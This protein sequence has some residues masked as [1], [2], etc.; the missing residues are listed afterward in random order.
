MSLKC[1]FSIC[2]TYFDEMLF[3]GCCS[4]TAQPGVSAAA[5]VGS[6]RGGALGRGLGADL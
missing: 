3:V 5:H 2:L 4:Y 6:A 1:S